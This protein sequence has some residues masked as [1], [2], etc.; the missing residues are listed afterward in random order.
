MVDY[1]TGLIFK[2]YRLHILYNVYTLYITYTVVYYFMYLHTHLLFLYAHIQT[3]LFNII[4]IIGFYNGTIHVFSW[5]SFSQRSHVKLLNWHLNKATN[6]YVFSM[7]NITSFLYQVFLFINS[8]NLISC[9]SNLYLHSIWPWS[10]LIY[11][12]S[13]LFWNHL[14]GMLS[15]F[16]F[17]NPNSIHSSQTCT[18]HTFFTFSVI[19]P[20]LCHIMSMET[21]QNFLN[22]IE[23]FLNAC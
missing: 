2:N 8:S 19:T 6:A 1:I 21:L 5:Y 4:L 13:C 23:L 20:H 3:I 18:I 17:K 11:S 10:S 14:S 12:T 9:H 22:F 15:S 16:F 7:E